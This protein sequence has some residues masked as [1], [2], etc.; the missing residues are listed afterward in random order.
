MTRTL[1]S[2]SVPHHFIL[3]TPPKLQRAREIKKK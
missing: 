3:G 2:P 1:L